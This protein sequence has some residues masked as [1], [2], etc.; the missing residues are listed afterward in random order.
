M[1]ADC[2]ILRVL[3]MGHGSCSGDDRDVRELARA[4]AGIFSEERA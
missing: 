1:T 3:G 2:N 4:A